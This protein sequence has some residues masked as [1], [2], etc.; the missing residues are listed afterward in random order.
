MI[1]DD[2]GMDSASF[3]PEGPFRL[4]TNPPA[5]PMPNLTALARGGVVFG[6]FWVQQEC[7]P[8]RATLATGQYGFRRTNGVGQWITEGRPSLPTEALTLPEA[9]RAASVGRKY[10]LAH[11]GKWHL[12]RLSEGRAM[13]AVH[14]WP[15]YQGPFAGGAL[16]NYF[17]YKKYS[18][19]SGVVQPDVR[20]RIYAT[21]DQVNDTISVIN[22][23]NTPPRPYFITLALNAPH[24]PYHVPPNHLH[25]RDDL[26]IV[27]APDKALTRSYYEA[28][29]EAVDTEL[30][31]LIRSVDLTSTTVFVLSDNGTPGYVTAPPYAGSHGK[32]TIY[33]GGIR[34]PLLAFGAQV[35][36]GAAGRVVDAIVAGVDLFPTI[37]E[38]A[39]I[40]YR[41]V[42]PVG[43]RIDGVSLVPYFSSPT[44]PSIPTHA[45]LYSDKFEGTWDTNYRRAIRDLN[46][47]LVDRPGTTA[48]QLFH[49]ATDPLETVNLLTSPPLSSG[50]GSALTKLR[51]NLAKLLAT[52]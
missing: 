51:A 14:G 11:I 15:F 31:R 25:S 30:G 1:I 8:T 16:S 17:D 35:A 7:S 49:L 24:A 4:R 21:T 13:P 10:K 48:D 5:P 45:Y 40:D 34:V 29:I 2:F 33:E 19:V 39:G 9:F 43:S 23:A 26:P 22:Q 46:Y 28:M 38:L 47:K 36:D 32:S 27:A 12:S 44:P 6:N 20:T 3:V 42:V 37:L 18:V 52:R 41:A 50:A